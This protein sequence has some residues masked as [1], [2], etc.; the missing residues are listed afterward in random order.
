[1]NTPCAHIHCAMRKKATNLTLSE[2]IRDRACRIMQTQG[3]SR[4]TRRA[5]TIALALIALAV[6]AQTTTDPRP[7]AFPF[8]LHPTRLSIGLAGQS[9]TTLDTALRIDTTTGQTAVLIARVRVNTTDQQPELTAYWLPVDD[10]TR[11]TTPLA[12]KPKPTSN[13]QRHQ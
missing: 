7:S 8:K 4:I 11:P 9:M 10:P 5:A 12:E 3:F 13:P 6:L 1:M 2:A